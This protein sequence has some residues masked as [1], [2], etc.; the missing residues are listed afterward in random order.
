MGISSRDYYRSD[1]ASGDGTGWLSDTP[2][3]RW[4][5]VA[6]VIVYI[7]QL[8]ITT[9]E[10]S[11]ELL[12]SFGRP[13]VITESL[14]DQWFAMDVSAVLHGQ[15]WRLLS[16][17]FLHNRFEPLH[18]IFNMLGLWFFGCTLERM[19][20]SREFMKFYLVAA[21]IGSV[22]YL[23]LS[24][25]LQTS[26]GPMMGASG[27]TMAVFMLYGAHF[28]RQHIMIFWV[29]PIEI[30]WALAFYIA[31]DLFPVLHL[32]GGT[33][34]HT[35]VAHAAH[36]A[37][38]LFGW[39][40]YRNG[41]RLENGWISLTR[42]LSFRWRRATTGRQFKVYRPVEEDPVV[43]IDAEVDRILAKIHEHGTGSLTAREQ[44]VMAQASERYKRK[45]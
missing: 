4:I 17:A 7:L 10:Q 19:Y 29:I 43:D 41:W 31:M 11:P 36:L 23:L 18:L 9:R 16:Y 35:G 3:V 20:S 1:S 42:T 37:G 34:L 30:R 2:T 26:G 39:L 5:I 25:A 44:A 33:N 45:L 24:M 21:L 15:V 32:I 13:A 6:T 38:L 28:P 40:Y 22:G 8:V 14:V 27:A 12:D